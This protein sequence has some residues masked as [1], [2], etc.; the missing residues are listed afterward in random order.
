MKTDPIRGGLRPKTRSNRIHHMGT[1]GGS[2]II[3]PNKELILVTNLISPDSLI[4]YV[5]PS[6]PVK[7]CSICATK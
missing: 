6:C 1:M 7:S 5:E 2:S 4:F 3:G